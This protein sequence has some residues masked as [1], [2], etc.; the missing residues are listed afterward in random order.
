MYYVGVNMSFD[1]LYYLVVAQE[2][3]ED[4]TAIAQKREA[5]LRCS[6]SRAYYSAFHHAKYTLYDKWNILVSE[7]VS[8]HAQIWNFFKQKGEKDVAWKLRYMRNARNKADYEDQVANLE[9]LAQEVL[10]LAVEVI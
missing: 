9:N 4:T 10:K 6:I 8:A 3:F 5:N 7:S 2:L 1:W